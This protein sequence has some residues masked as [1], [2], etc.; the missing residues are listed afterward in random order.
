MKNSTVETLIGTA[1]VA[2]A[3]AFFMFAY[4]TSDKGAASG[5]GTLLRPAPVRH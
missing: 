1:V 4:N 3:A 5:S 2:I